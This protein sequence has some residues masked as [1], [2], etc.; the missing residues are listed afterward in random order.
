MFRDG[1]L[2]EGS[3]SNIWVVK[4]GRL[5]APPRDALILE[6]IRYGLLEDLAGSQGVPF[7][8]RRIT[9]EEVM[10]ADELMATSATKEILPIAI[11]DGKQVGDGPGPVYRKLLDAYQ[12]AKAASV[13]KGWTRP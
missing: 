4:G 7:D 3:A 6:G 11:L 5:L 12:V 10:T 1:Y 2:T 9:R 8:I 13:A